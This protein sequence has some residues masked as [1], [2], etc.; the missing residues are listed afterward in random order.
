[1]KKK[2]DKPNPILIAVN[3]TQSSEIFRVGVKIAEILDKSKLDNNECMLATCM[4][5]ALRGFSLEER[6]V[7]RKDYLESVKLNIDNIMTSLK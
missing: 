5:L 7:D 1:M 3:I 4:I 2:S 6:G